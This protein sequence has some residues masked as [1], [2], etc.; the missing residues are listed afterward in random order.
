MMDNEILTMP[1]AEP[2]PQPAPQ[3]MPRPIFAYTAADTAVA[4]TCLLIGFLFHRCVNLFSGGELISPLFGAL[5]TAGLFTAALV[6][7]GV[8]KKLTAQTV[9]V[10]ISGV[11]AG[12]SLILTANAFL[13]FFAFVYAAA[14]FLYVVYC[15]V[16]GK[17]E[18]G[19]SSLLFADLFRA[20]FVYPFAS[21]PFLFPALRG[22]KG[23]KGGRVFLKVMIGLAIAVI[24]TAIVVSLLSYDEGFSAILNTLFNL[25]KIG[26][27]VLRLMLGVPVAMYLFGLYNTGRQGRCTT[28]MGAERCHTAGKKAHIA[29]AVTLLAATLPMMAIYVIYFIS[30]WQYYVSGFLGV[31]PTQLKAAE[32]ARNGFFELCTVAAINLGVVILVHLLAKRK[33]E[34][35]T[36]IARVLVTLF[37]AATLVLLATAAAKMALYV[38]RFGLTPMR[39]YAS[40]F[41]GVIAVLFLMVLVKQFAPR[42]AIVPVGAA[43]TVILFLT[44][45]LS[46]V[47]GW[48]ARYN[49]ERYWS[50]A[51]STVD[52][53]AMEEL[54]DSALPVLCELKASLD[55]K[56]DPKAVALR[57]EVDCLLDTAAEDLGS[58][59]ESGFFSFD[60][61]RARAVEALKAAGYLNE[62]GRYPDPFAV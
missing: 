33:A 51:L 32:Y 34:K 62:Q 4:W 24:P 49:V 43:V 59:E 10:A 52:T 37:T 6:F 2:Q 36:W 38:D 46:G 30:Q 19:L 9:A 27:D 29:P 42:F 53:E 23:Q 54:G 20:L 26:E 41:M 50:G 25:S 39:V 3:E 12:V 47:D 22:E 13:H 60:L 5:F 21:F 58:E 7:F 28:V 8:Q 31:L 45:T 16:G 57:E 17:L 56:S 40:W 61:P 18:K 55:D 15:A 44:L 35:P 14:A 1:A 11:A 48:I